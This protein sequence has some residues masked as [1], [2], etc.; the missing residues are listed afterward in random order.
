MFCNAC[1]F[2][3]VNEKVKSGNA[4]WHLDLIGE[5]LFM[6]DLLA[7]N[8]LTVLSDVLTVFFSSPLSHLANYF[9]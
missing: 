7:N 8:I 6:G 9:S 5:F 4:E 1:L 2:L 3:C